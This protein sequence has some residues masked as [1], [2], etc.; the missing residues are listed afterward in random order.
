MKNNQRC[1]EIP[2]VTG[3]R[4]KWPLHLFTTK[5]LDAL[6]LEKQKEAAIRTRATTNIQISRLLYEGTALR[7]QL[8]MKQRQ[9]HWPCST[10]NESLYSK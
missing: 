4:M 9:H 2:M 1:T 7:I 6:I 10:S 8:G 5:Q 3:K